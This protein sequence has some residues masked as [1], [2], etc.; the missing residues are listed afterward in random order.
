MRGYICGFPFGRYNSVR[1]C[2]C[3]GVGDG[4]IGVFFGDNV[5]YVIFVH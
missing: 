2:W 1:V 3:C 5:S 4:V